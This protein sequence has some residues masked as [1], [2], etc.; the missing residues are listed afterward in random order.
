MNRLAEWEIELD[1]HRSLRLIE[2]RILNLFP[3]IDNLRSKVHWKDDGSPVTEADFLI[4]SELKLIL[5]GVFT[6]VDLI[7]E[8]SYSQGQIRGND[9]VAVLDPIDGTENFASGLKEWGT[10]LS[11]W[12]R[13]RHLAS[14]LLLP[15]LGQRLVTGTGA[16]KHR[17]RIAGYSS[18]MSKGLISKLDVSKENRITGCAVLNLYNVI[19]GRFA[20]FHNPVGAYSW[21]LLAGLQLALENN[22]EV[23]IDG[24]KY[25]GQYLAPG[26]R[27]IVEIWGE[28]PHH[29]NG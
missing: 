14:M 29:Y 7:G 11:L 4:E 18:S 3:R 12:W 16:T 1:A 27:Y 8:E 17:S 25:Q 15:E 6:E 28:Q 26:R 21:D 2:E 22:C 20:S 9:L 5:E 10:S 23:M 19:T 13:N 24:Q